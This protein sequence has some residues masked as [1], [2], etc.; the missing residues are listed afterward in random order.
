MPRS[1]PTGAVC[2]GPRTHGKK[3]VALIQLATSS[4]FIGC[5]KVGPRAGNRGQVLDRADHE[6]AGGGGPRRDAAPVLVAGPSAPSSSPR[7]E[8]P[9]L[10]ATRP[11]AHG[12]PKPASRYAAAPSRWRSAS[13]ACRADT[14]SGDAL[15]AFACGGP[16]PEGTSDAGGPKCGPIA[17]KQQIALF[18]PI[19]RR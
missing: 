1:Q 15:R 17:S 14:R 18:T 16:C 10:G 12:S 4:C 3:I 7:I 2:L 13:A 9:P 5:P 11:S 19:G 8:S 6:R